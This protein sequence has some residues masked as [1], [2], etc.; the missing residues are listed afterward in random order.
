[1]TFLDAYAKFGPDTMAIAEALEIKEH[2]ADTL[3]NMKMN[4]DYLRS[5][6]ERLRAAGR[7]QPGPRKPIRFAGYDETERSW[8]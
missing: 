1:M 6:N 3:I 7:Q 8:W 2:E 5:G 4:R